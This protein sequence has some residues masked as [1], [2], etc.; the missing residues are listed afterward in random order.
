[1]R[2]GDRINSSK[3]STSSLNPSVLGVVEGMWSSGRI[4]LSLFLAHLFFATRE[5][6]VEQFM[7]KILNR[8]ATGKLKAISRKDSSSTCSSRGSCPAAGPCP[9]SRELWDAAD[10]AQPGQKKSS[11]ASHRLPCWPHA[12]PYPHSLQR[13]QKHLVCLRRN[14]RNAMRKHITGCW[15]NPVT[16]ATPPGTVFPP[17]T[18]KVSEMER[19]QELQML[20]RHISLHI[21]VLI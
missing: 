4:G 20:P 21:F 1:M 9:Q 7:F 14:D 12:R 3:S 15:W 19:R 10:A 6:P 8:K 16:Y 2:F 17:H 18:V 11:R 13:E 5:R